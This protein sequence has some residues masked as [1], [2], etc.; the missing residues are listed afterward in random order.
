MYTI[1]VVIKGS[2]WWWFSA[3]LDVYPLLFRDDESILFSTLLSFFSVE[4]TNLCW[5]HQP[6]LKS[7]T[8]V[9][10]TNLCWNHQ[11]LL[12]SPTFVEITN[13]C[14]NHQPLLKSPTFVEITNLWKNHQPFPIR[15]HEQLSDYQYQDFRMPWSFQLWPDIGGSCWLQNRPNNHWI[16]DWDPPFATLVHSG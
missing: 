8:F 1:L 10:I 15:I 5:N 11:P 14:W 12:K 13:L 4:I 7:P 9:E 16:L 2:S 6:L 3:I